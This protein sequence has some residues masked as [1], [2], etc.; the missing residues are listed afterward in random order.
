[1]TDR[2]Y[3]TTAIAYV[4]STPHIGFALECVQ[5]DCFARYHRL[6]GEETYFLSGTDEN[7]LKNVQAAEAEGLPVQE[8]VAR[9]SERFRALD[10]LLH[11]SLDQFIRTSADPRHTPASQKLWEACDRN[12][13]IYKKHYRGL[14]CVRCEK[15]LD[16]DELE[17]GKCPVHLVEPEVVEEENY[18]FRLSRYGRQLHDLI[19]SDRYRI[20]PETRKNEVLSFIARGLQDFSI[21]RSQERAHGWGVPVP[22]D[23]SQVIYVWFDALTNYISA[24]GYADDGPL[25]ETYWANNRRKTHCIG[26]DIIRFHAVYWPAMLLSAGLPLPET[27]F[28]HGFITAAGAKIS[29]SSGPTVDPVEL[30][31]SYGVEAVR[32]YLL[33]A[34]NPTADTDFT[35]ENFEQRYN[36][37]LANDLGNLLNRTVS[38]VDRYRSGRVPAGPEG[39]LE[40][41]VRQTAEQVERAARAAL[42]QYDPRGALDAVWTLVTRTN[43]FVEESAPWTLAKAARAGDDGS[44]ERLDAS[45][46]TMVTALNAI[47]ALLQPFLPATSSAIRRQLGLPEEILSWTESTWQAVPE[48]TQVTKGRPLFPRLEAE[49]AVS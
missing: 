30:V 3:I 4:N 25:Y 10:D 42:D 6:I 28:V 27:L 38:M 34:V 33:R 24:L 36:T 17:N 39:E 32:Y 19:A 29:K 9:N 12:G 40:A 45:L 22:G 35:L 5:A 43:R 26:K 7:A 1:M 37:D 48:G 11:V 23:P 14:Y 21:S 44:T 47:A 31:E 18:F 13:D 46:A 15:F 8:L 49:A 41:Q 20:I 16:E 2:F